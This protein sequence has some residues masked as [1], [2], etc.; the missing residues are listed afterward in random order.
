MLYTRDLSGWEN[1]GREFQNLQAFTPLAKEIYRK[2][3]IPFEPLTP[4]TPGTNAVFRSGNT[5][6]KIYTPIETGLSGKDGFDIELFS[7]R[8]AMKCGFSSPNVLASGY[9]DDKY[10]FYYIIMEYIDAPEFQF[11]RASFSKDELIL[12]S[13]NF[14]ERLRCLN[15]PVKSFTPVDACAQ[16]IS[17]RRWDKLPAGFK[18][19]A[20]SV[21]KCAKKEE[22]VYVHG[23]LNGDNVLYKDGELFVIDFAD[24]NLAPAFL[25]SVCV[26]VDLFDLDL[27][28]AQSFTALSGLSLAHHLYRGLLLHA[29]GAEI[30]LQNIKKRFGDTAAQSPAHLLKA[31]EDWSNGRY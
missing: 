1:W 11:V 18:E 21:A 20:L 7:M 6:I 16:V 15:V 2:N 25:E 28:C 26:T 10:R 23:D 31:L 22:Q 13:K 30:I 12:L 29:F 4:L 27:G 9:I 17:N 19:E 24:S 14:S 8:H 5:V 3:R